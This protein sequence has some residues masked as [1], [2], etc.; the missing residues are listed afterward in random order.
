MKLL[1]N[2]FGDTPI[3]VEGFSEE[4][5]RSCK[6]SLHVLPRKIKTITLDEYEYIK[7]KYSHI[8]K[9][10]RVLAKKEE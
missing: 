7:L 10:I 8:V 2:Y 3:Y 6:G 5:E 4:C 9:K 1:I